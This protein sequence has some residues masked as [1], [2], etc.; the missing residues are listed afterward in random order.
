MNFT[1]QY[2]EEVISI[3][4]RVDDAKIE[5]IVK[6][7]KKIRE[8]Q[9]RIFVLG[10][11]GSAGNAS[12]MVNDL[13]K[14]CNIEAYAPT[15]NVSELTARV[16]DSLDGWNNFFVDYLKTSHFTWKD[17]VF[18]LSVGG[19]YMGNISINLLNACEYVKEI[20][21]FVLGIVGKEF[22]RIPLNFPEYCVI[23]PHLEDYLRVTPHSEA[24]Q[25]I[26]WHCIV[27]HPLLQINNTTW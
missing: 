27:S 23:V 20:D 22:G 24:F 17:A 7:M 4:C 11:G 15:D 5:H 16:N 14:I 19:A 12:H 21:G 18:V 9:G 25:S 26:I 13:R 10:V 2:M 8:A 1:R 3:A 6:L